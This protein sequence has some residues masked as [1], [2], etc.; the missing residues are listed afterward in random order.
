MKTRLHAPET[1]VFIRN[2]QS[3]EICA[4]YDQDALT[5]LIRRNTLRPLNRE[6]F[7]PEMITIKDKCH[8]NIIK[9]CFYALPI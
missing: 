2:A 8:F 7:A 9:Q 3:S 1:G 4:L 6:R 5:E